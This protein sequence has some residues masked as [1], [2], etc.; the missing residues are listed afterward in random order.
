[1]PSEEYEVPLIMYS[2]DLTALEFWHRGEERLK[3][4]P[5]GMAETRCEIVEYKL[6]EM[7]C[8]SSMT[9]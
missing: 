7:F 3:H 8:R 5:N 9:L 1:M 6:G 4:P 2:D